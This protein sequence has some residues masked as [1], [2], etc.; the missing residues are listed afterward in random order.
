[1]PGSRADWRSNFQ[2]EYIYK[3]SH[4]VPYNAGNALFVDQIG[5]ECVGS[6]FA[7]RGGWG[8]LV[9]D[10]SEDAPLAC[11]SP[12]RLNPISALPDPITDVLQDLGVS[13][14]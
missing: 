4:R 10:T 7:Q 2:G 8:A 14:V 1:L 13:I 12:P 9:V 5:L 3:V 11:S 6:P